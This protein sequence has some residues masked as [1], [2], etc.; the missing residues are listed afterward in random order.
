MAAKPNVDREKPSAPE[1]QDPSRQDID[2]SVK[3][4]EEECIEPDDLCPICH[5][6][7]YRPVTTRRCSHT[8]CES[9]LAYWADVSFSFPNQIR[10]RPLGEM[11]TDDD[12][13]D[14]EISAK[15][16][17]CRTLTVASFNATL[18]ETLKARYP[19]QYAER[20]AEEETTAAAIYSVKT[21][22]VYIGNLHRL[23]KPAN[24]MS[25]NSHE[26][27]FFVRPSRTDIIDH[28]IIHLHPTFRSPVLGFEHPPYEVRRVGWGTFRIDAEIQLERGWQW[29]S[30]DAETALNGQENGSLPLHWYLDFVGHGSQGRVKLK[31]KK[32]P[33]LGTAASTTDASLHFHSEESSS[34]SEDMSESSDGWDADVDEESEPVETGSEETAMAGSE[35]TDEEATGDMDTDERPETSETDSAYSDET[36]QGLSS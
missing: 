12:G 10:L 33:I 29:V 23:T 35:G 17:M 19:G 20:Q 22:T 2:R 9:C 34:E 36:W 1:I 14:E 27:K 11:P 13:P 21:L 30:N 32:V 7:L 26:W 15:C 3:D 4:H 18:E 25:T 5:L 6:L 31:I 28:V 8:L 16:P 24:S